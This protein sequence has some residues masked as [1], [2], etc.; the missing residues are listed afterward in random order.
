MAPIRR[1]GLVEDLLSF[2]EKIN[3]LLEESGTDSSG[4]LGMG[5]RWA[6]PVDIFEK[7]EFFL[8]M[9]DLPGVGL[10][11][12]EVEVKDGSL[13]IKGGRS[14]E[15]DSDSTVVLKQERSSGVF[16]RAFTLPLNAD[17]ENVKAN[18]KDGILTVTVPKKQNA[19]PQQI[20][21]DLL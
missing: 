7:D 1:A 13:H 10:E 17:Q 18:F 2:H 20:T 21:V 4:N 16:H 15:D 19:G 11:N 9:V 8:L 12:V 14:L 6:P 5:G 3:K